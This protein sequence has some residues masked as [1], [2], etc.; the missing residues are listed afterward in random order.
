MTHDEWM[1]CCAALCELWPQRPMPPESAE[2]WYPLLADLDG[3]TVLAAIQ[4]VAL[5][6]ANTWPPSLGELRAAAEPMPR[7][8]EDALGSLRRLMA[9]RGV[10]DPP[11]EPD[12]LG[13]DALADVID[14]YGWA[15]ICSLN[16]R[17][18]TDRAQFRDAYRAA[19]TRQ[20]E[21]TR[22]GIA[23]RTA[24]ALCAPKR[25]MLSET[26]TD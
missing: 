9:R 12:E 5:D 25:A 8:W 18:T 21:Q 6:P 4:A 26:R 17:D 15:A 24:A 10:Y 20:R 22:R 16:P 13:D 7:S 23:A 1:T 3:Q 11:P 19:Q 2:A 14:S